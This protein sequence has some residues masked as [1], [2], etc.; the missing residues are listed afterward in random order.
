MLQENYKWID[1]LFGKKIELKLL[2]CIL[3]FQFNTKILI[4]KK[5]FVKKKNIMLKFIFEQNVFFFLVKILNI[6]NI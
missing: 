6:Q 5:I 1:T 4:K 3:N 2:F